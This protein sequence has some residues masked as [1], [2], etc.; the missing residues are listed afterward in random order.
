MKRVRSKRN[1]RQRYSQKCKTDK[2]PS[3]HSGIENTG[4]RKPQIAPCVIDDEQES[5]NCAPY[6]KH[7]ISSMPKSAKDHN[8]HHIDI[9]ADRAVTVSAQR[10]VQIVPQ[11]S[12][13]RDVPSS[14]ELNDPRRLVR[15]VEI[16]RKLDSEHT[17]EAH[18][19]VGVTGE[20]VVKLEAIG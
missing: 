10:K 5:V 14:P 17:R 6:R 4:L 8:Y 18:S 9:A 3:H 1:P 19:H 13:Q 2:T 16:C 11:E 15:G 7:P 20:V 12:R